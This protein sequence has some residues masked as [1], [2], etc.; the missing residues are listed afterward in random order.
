MVFCGLQGFESVFVFDL[1]SGDVIGQL[2]CST[3]P[4]SSK[5][6]LTKLAKS[7]DKSFNSLPYMII[8]PRSSVVSTSNDSSAS[9]LCILPLVVPLSHIPLLCS[10]GGNQVAGIGWKSN[11]KEMSSKRDSLLEFSSNYIIEEESYDFDTPA[12]AAPPL[13]PDSRA[14]L[15]V[16]MDLGGTYMG[17]NKIDLM[18]PRVQA[19]DVLTSM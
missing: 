10:T 8:V 16:S 6:R 11:H 5:K 7:K 17:G 1:I 18:T 14:G 13:R 3:D 12:P 4:I 9:D 15:N 19:K 2:E